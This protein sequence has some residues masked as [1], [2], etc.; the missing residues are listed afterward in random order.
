MNIISAVFQYGELI[1]ARYTCD[2]DDINPSFVFSD[3]PKEAKSLVMIMDDPD[4]PIGNWVHWTMWNIDP[5]IGIMPENERLQGV[6]E[7]M[8][9]FGT[10]GYGG[11][12]PNKGTH[13][14]FF[15]LYALDTFLDLPSNTTKNELMEAMRG[16]ILAEAE[17]MGKYKRGRECH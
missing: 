10:S 1:P 16:H 12:C 9:N 5:K 3:I 8:T 4:S 6:S 13:R 15:N 11:P 17:L 2:G 14:Y 7:G